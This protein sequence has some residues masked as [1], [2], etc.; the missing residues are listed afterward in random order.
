MKTELSAK[1]NDLADILEKTAVY[2]DKL[3]DKDTSQEKEAFHN[4]YVAPVVKKM[5]KAM[6]DEIDDDLKEKLASADPEI[7]K[8]MKKLAERNTIESS[9]SMGG[10]SG[11]VVKEAASTEEDALLNF[12]LS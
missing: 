4:N 1:L 7:L 6:G 3:E 2:V 9:D 5:S 12:C 10:P 8:A 11:Y